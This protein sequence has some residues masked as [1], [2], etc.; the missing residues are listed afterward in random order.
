M[1]FN[2]SIINITSFEEWIEFLVRVGLIIKNEN[3]TLTNTLENS[4]FLGFLQHHN[5]DQNKPF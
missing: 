5:Y 2:Q 4:G 3:N 1:K